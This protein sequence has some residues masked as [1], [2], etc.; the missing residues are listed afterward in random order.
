[1]GKAVQILSVLLRILPDPKTIIA[2]VVLGF[3]S[4][5]YLK[6]FCVFLV[7]PKPE[8]KDAYQRYISTCLRSGVQWKFY[9][10]DTLAQARSLVQ[11][12]EEEEAKKQGSSLR[13]KLVQRG[14]QT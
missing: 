14:Q 1:M 5:F 10:C 6:D 8:I 13:T 3:V 7:S 4:G 11:R 9:I 2:G 12:H